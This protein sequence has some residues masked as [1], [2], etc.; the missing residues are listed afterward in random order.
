MVRTPRHQPD[1]NREY[2]KIYF[3]NRQLYFRQ[4][5]ENSTIQCAISKRKHEWRINRINNCI[6]ALEKVNS[7]LTEIKSCQDKDQDKSL[8]ILLKKVVIGWNISCEQKGTSSKLNK[9]QRKRDIWDFIQWISNYLP[10]SSLLFSA[11]PKPALLNVWILEQT[12]RSSCL[13]FR[14]YFKL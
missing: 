5:I 1:K 14:M 2:D 10:F 13:K 8:T 4:I 6:K 7:K 3:Q 12:R 11:A 9:V